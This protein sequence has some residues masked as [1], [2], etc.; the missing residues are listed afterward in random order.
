[1]TAN[2]I[3]LAR[4]KHIEIDFHFTRERVAA[5]LLE[6]LHVPAEKQIADMFMKSLPSGAF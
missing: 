5:G 6:V 3:F 1:M 4:S 2:P